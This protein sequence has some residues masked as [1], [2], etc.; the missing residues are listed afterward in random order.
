MYEKTAKKRLCHTSLLARY[1]RKELDGDGRDKIQERVGGIKPTEEIYVRED[2][3]EEDA[4]SHVV[5][6]SLRSIGTRRG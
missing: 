4:V 6:S 5:G 1:A 2:S 3:R